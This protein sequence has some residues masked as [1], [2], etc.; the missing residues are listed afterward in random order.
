MLIIHE[1][2]ILHLKVLSVDGASIRLCKTGR[3]KD[4]A[5]ILPHFESIINLYGGQDDY[6]DAVSVLGK[7]KYFPSGCDISIG[8]S[9]TGDKYYFGDIDIRYGHCS[10]SLFVSSNLA[11]IVFKDGENLLVIFKIR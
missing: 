9:I 1:D 3:F 11:P 10:G 4:K 5:L 8:Y 7:D 2:D 6:C